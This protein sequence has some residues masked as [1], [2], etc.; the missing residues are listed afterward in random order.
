M[1]DVEGD[2]SG[3][4]RLN[5]WHSYRCKPVKPYMHCPKGN[6][7]EAKAYYDGNVMSGLVYLAH[8]VSFLV[9]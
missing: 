4:D 7:P 1:R 8:G 9:E 5:Q 2:W 3:L 6:D